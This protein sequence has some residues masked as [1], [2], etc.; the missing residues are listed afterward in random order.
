MNTITHTEVIETLDGR[1]IRQWEVNGWRVRQLEFIIKTSTF[2]NRVLVV[3][4][5]EKPA[6]L[7]WRD[8]RE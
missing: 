3:F 2:K 7:H 8:T 4:E 1:E 5:T 6:A